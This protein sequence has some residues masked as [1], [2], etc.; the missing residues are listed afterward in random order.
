MTHSPAEEPKLC[1]LCGKNEATEPYA[2]SKQTEMI[3]ATCLE[4][5]RARDA[6]EDRLIYITNLEYDRRY[7]AAL[8][9]LDEILEANRHRD[10]DLWL[11]RSIAMLR[12]SILFNAGRYAEAEKACEAWAQLGFRNIHD[13]WMHAFEK[14]QTLN[15]LGRPREALAVVEDGLGHQDPRY[16]EAAML[17]LTPL[18]RLSKKLGQPV[19]PKWRGLAE[20]W[21][22][23]HEIDMPVGDSLEKT[24]LELQKIYRARKPEFANDEGAEDEADET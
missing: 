6:L 14:A 15:A 18:V 21:A 12:S 17:L 20:A 10:H 23:H 11:A 24:I 8:A 9:C 19:D 5:R 22:R 3:C 16:I 1:W 7:D 13:R 4:R 2:L